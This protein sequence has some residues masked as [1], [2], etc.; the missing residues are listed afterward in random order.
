MFN[1]TAKAAAAIVASD[2][3]TAHVICTTTDAS[4]R[5]AAQLLHEHRVGALPV[6]NAAGAPVGM[7][8]DGDLLGRR[9]GQD[10]GEWWLEMLARGTH[11]AEL[12]AEI[13]DRPVESVMTS[14]LITIAPNTPVAEIAQRMRAH[15]IKRLP[16][17]RD[18]TIVGLVSRTDLLDLVERL[19]TG[20][21]E[22]AGGLGG[23]FGSFAGRQRVSLAERLAAAEAADHAAAATT[24]LSAVSFRSMVEAYKHEQVDAA[25]KAK[26]AAEL[27]RQRQVKAVLEQRVSGEFWQQLLNHAAL[28][29]KHG[30]RELLLLRFPADAC[31][32]GGR[33]INIREEGWA[34][35]LRGEAA[36]LYARWN[37]ELKAKGFG[38]DARVLS[39]ENGVIGDFGLY[40]T[41]GG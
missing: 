11:P 38:L 5:S 2:I 14:P 15:R 7:A 27:E 6:L 19:P 21:A 22:K 12:S 39:F 9:V 1:H 18:G 31:S 40:L 33:K 25:T 24:N 8:S 29:A 28:A 32:D 4:V 34:E 16:V 30:E 37:N 26:H 23:L 20:E 10:R 35:T 41:W 17:V 36:E 13:Y 3:M